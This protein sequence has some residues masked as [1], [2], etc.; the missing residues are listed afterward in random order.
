MRKLEEEIQYLFDHYPNLFQERWQALDQLFCLPKNG[1]QWREGR[2]VEI[3]Q[4]ENKKVY[5]A[6]L[7]NGRAKQRNK[8][9]EFRLPT[10]C[11]YRNGND[12]TAIPKDV[13]EDWLAGYEETIQLIQQTKK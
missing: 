5:K 4:S 2:M 1:Y 10:M 3:H 8:K 6:L 9:T 7:E 12:I 11:F 13:T